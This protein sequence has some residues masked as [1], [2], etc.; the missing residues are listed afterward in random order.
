MEILTGSTTAVQLLD[1]INQARNDDVICVD[2]CIDA[3]SVFDSV[4][5]EIVK[6]PYDK[7]LLLHALAMR[8]HLDAGR[9]RKLIW[10]D[11]VDMV[12]DGLTKGS[13]DREALIR[14][15]EKGEWELGCCGLGLVLQGLVC[16]FLSIFLLEHLTAGAGVRGCWLRG[17]CSG[18]RWL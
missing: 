13:I 10:I 1:V 4:T 17:C 18:Q 5:A 16:A 7:H 11:T 15:S 6:T 8:E 3:R 12:S 2:G 14:L 9:L